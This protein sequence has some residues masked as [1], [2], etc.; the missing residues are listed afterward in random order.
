MEGCVDQVGALFRVVGDGRDRRHHDGH[1]QGHRT[2]QFYYVMGSI[3]KI[4][5][6]FFNYDGLAMNILSHLAR[7]RLNQELLFQDVTNSILINLTQKEYKMNGP[8][9]FL[10]RFLGMKWRPFGNYFKGNWRP[11]IKLQ[12][13]MALISLAL[14]IQNLAVYFQFSVSFSIF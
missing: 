5:F 7:L 1:A 12:E 4:K 11:L 9:F 13:M 6:L 2:E 14:K 10:Q 3:F 8:V